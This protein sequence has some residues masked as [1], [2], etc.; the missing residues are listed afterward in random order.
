MPK[1]TRNCESLLK[2]VTI[3]DP[4]VSHGVS[5]NDNSYRNAAGCAEFNPTDFVTFGRF[6]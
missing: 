3:N 2:L 6:H 1:I 4:V 5:I